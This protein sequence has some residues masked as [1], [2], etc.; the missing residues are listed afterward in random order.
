MSETQQTK[1]GVSR[2]DFLKIAGLAGAAATAGGFFLGGKAQGE[3]HKSYTGWESQNPG[4][5][6]FNRKPF[7]FEGPAH[8]PVGEVSRASHATDYVFGRVAMFQ[9]AYEANPSWTMD[10]PIEDLGLIPPVLAFYKKFPER[11]EWDFRTFSETIPN[12]I[13]DKK[14]YGNYF[15]LA[16]AYESGWSA[17]A[18]PLSPPQ[19]P[20]EESDFSV[21]GRGG[22]APL[23]EQIPFKSPELAADFVKEMAHRYGAT[24]VGITQAR[25][26]YFYADGWRGAPEGYDHSKLPEHWQNVIV[27]GVPMEWDVIL[28]SPHF[29]TSQDAYNRVSLAALRVEGLLKYLGYAARANTPNTNYD[30]LVPPHA[31]EAGLGEVGRTGYCITPELGGNC[32]MAAVVT[33]MPLALDKPIDY[34][35][36]EFCNKCK[37]CAESCPSGAISMADSPDGLEIRGYEHWYINNGACYNY[38][39]E[40]MGPMGCRLC[41]ATCPYSRKD[42][43]LHDMART[44]DP[45]D[46]T[47]VTSSGLLWLQ[48]NFF[49]YPEAIEYR[50]PA[51]G[52]HFASYRPEPDYMKAETYLNIPIT[53]PHEGGA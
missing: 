35:V 41:V 34:G 51:E 44:L 7:E 22:P 28:G 3:S 38:W 31:I 33:N 21:M 20:P 23:G 52:G 46:P 40:T 2:R 37:L 4:T 49:D 5:Q 53:S 13:E 47:G 11:L 50:R 32:R 27:I 48:K 45:R 39:R 14:K 8:T 9:T 16:D 30:L 43:W 17:T 1:A 6:F 29:S 10:D 15:K 12:N 18:A 36:A 19:L 42:N 24:L 25:L 26:D